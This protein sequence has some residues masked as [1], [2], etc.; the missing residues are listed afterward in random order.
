MQAE[1]S[2]TNP[3]PKEKLHLF[4]GAWPV[5]PKGPRQPLAP[6]G[7]ALYFD[8]RPDRLQLSH[9]RLAGTAIQALPL[10]ACPAPFYK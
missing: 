1:I 2:A 4:M 9:P 5:V 10:S 6:L 3:T 7:L 8:H